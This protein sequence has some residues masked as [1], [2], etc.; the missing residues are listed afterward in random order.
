M[1]Y[2]LDKRGY[3]YNI[4]TQTPTLL[5]YCIDVYRSNEDNIKEKEKKAM[6]N[7]SEEVEYFKLEKKNILHMYFLKISL[8]EMKN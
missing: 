5:G 3:K 1:I 8:M 7:D 4:D 6:L 2:E